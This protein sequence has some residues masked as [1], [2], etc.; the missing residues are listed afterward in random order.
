MPL[1]PNI[2]PWMFENSWSA[3]GNP[4]SA[5]GPSGSSF[6]PSSLAPLGIHHLSPSNLTTGCCCFT[7]RSTAAA[8]WMDFQWFQPRGHSSQF[9]WRRNYY[10]WSLWATTRPVSGQAT[11]HLAPL[12]NSRPDAARWL[13]KLATRILTATQRAAHLVMNII[14]SVR[15]K[16]RCRYRDVRTKQSHWL[17]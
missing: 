9:R 17:L 14:W 15:G 13:A 2:V 16:V 6:G 11:C 12:I 5:L 4:T 3:V 8:E 7:A 1:K 10:E